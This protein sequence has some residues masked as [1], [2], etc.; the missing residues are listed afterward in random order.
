MHNNLRSQQLLNLQRRQI[1]VEWEL[2]QMTW[3]IRER[4]SILAQVI[5][6]LT[7]QREV[8]RQAH[9]EFMITYQRMDYRTF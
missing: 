5:A 7:E 2:T 4:R 1:E 9:A 6:L 8:S 3:L